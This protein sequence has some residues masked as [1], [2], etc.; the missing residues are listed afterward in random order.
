M[1]VVILHMAHSA[2]KV[3]ILLEDVPIHSGVDDYLRGKISLHDA[4]FCVPVV[5]KMTAFDYVLKTPFALRCLQERENCIVRST[6][7]YSP[8]GR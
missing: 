5:S 2:L 6:L 1:I 8:T 7:R 4:K 3:Q